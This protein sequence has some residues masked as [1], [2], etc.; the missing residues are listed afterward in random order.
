MSGMLE[1]A[2]QSIY[3]YVSMLLTDERCGVHCL[4]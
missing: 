2:L 3:M 4:G 1:W